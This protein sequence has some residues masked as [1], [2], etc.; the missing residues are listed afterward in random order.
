MRGGNIQFYLIN[1]KGKLQY[2]LYL[3]N[4]MPHKTIRVHRSGSMGN[5]TFIKNLDVVLNTAE[6][7]GW[8]VVAI[9]PINRGEYEYGATTEYLLVTLK[10]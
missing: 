7:E 10:K 9:T 3:R 2:H 4:S 5:S 8:G 1:K 6:T